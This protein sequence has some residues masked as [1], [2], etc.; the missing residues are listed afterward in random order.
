MSKPRV[1]FFDFSCC[2]GC[3]LQLTYYGKPFVDL[4][5]HIEVVEFREVMS[6]TTSEPIDVA[7]IEGSFTREADRARLESIRKRAAVVVAYGSCAATGNVNAL[8][9]N[10]PKDQVQEEVYGKDKNMPHLETNQEA[11]PISAA[12]KVDFALPGCPVDRTELLKLILDV[13]HGKAPYIPD[14]PVCVEC[15]L[16]GNICRYER[17]LWCL[18]P[19]TKA[20]CNAFCIEH[21]IACEGCRGYVSNANLDSMEQNLIEAGMDPEYASVKLRMFAAYHYDEM[22]KQEQKAKEQK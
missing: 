8:R 17:G 16:K 6:E 19:I 3:Q 18:G 5:D 10:R 14:Y 13:V 1:A 7:F 20:G 9:N 11:L 2:E 22:R 12:I 15:K 4:L 21:N